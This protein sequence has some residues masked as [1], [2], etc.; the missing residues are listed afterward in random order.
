MVFGVNKKINLSKRAKHLKKN[1]FYLVFFSRNIFSQ[2]MLKIFFFKVAT[3]GTLTLSHYF[4][5]S[6]KKPKYSPPFRYIY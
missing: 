6:G 2:K 5:F 3:T 4:F 1:I